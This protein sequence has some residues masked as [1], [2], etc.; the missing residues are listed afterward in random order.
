MI[1]RG[2]E[3]A[4]A[5]RSYA[6]PMD[7]TQS[8]LV[9]L[10]TMGTLGGLLLLLNARDRREAVL[11][12]AAWSLAP[13]CLRPLIAVQVRCALLSTASRVDVNLWG[14]ARDEI[15]E[16]IARW[17][18]GLPPRVR[19]RVTASMDNGG[20]PGVMVETTRA[21]GLSFT[22]GVRAARPRA[23]A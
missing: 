18:T 20:V 19:L 22:P 9:L 13:R 4:P 23:P 10:A 15:W 5:R 14:C 8:L 11:R 6:C 16:A 1:D 21:A 17:R 7:I 12:D 3:P 2:A